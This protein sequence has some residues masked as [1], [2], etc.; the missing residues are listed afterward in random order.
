MPGHVLEIGREDR[1]SSKP[2]LRQPGGFEGF[3]PGRV[4]TP[5]GEKAVTDREDLDDLDG[6]FVLT[7][8]RHRVQCD[9]GDDLITGVQ[10]F[11]YLDPTSFVVLPRVL[12]VL[13]KGLTAV[14][15]AVP[16]GSRVCMNLDLRVEI[17][18]HGV[19]ISL[20]ARLIGRLI[21]SPHKLEVLLRHGLRSISPESAAFHAKQHC[22][23]RISWR[24]ETALRR[25]P[26][27]GYY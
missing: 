26:F 19:V 17:R 2:L 24:R 9:H 5:L 13:P 3:V 1:F 11:L 27:P 18:H 21:G 12:D 14:V 23:W 7:A 10:E 20:A 16:R 6:D 8:L 15:D 4:L 22:R 25:G